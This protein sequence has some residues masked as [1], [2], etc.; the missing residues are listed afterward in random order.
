[1]KI[2][3]MLSD[4]ENEQRGDEH[5]DWGNESMHGIL[6][7]CF[8]DKESKKRGHGASDINSGCYGSFTTV[9]I[10]RSAV[11]QELVGI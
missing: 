10:N 7:I 3:W 4:V 9:R 2:T 11:A 5:P 6:G 8:R 1:M